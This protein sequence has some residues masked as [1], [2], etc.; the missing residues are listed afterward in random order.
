MND[1][2]PLVASGAHAQERAQGLNRRLSIIIRIIITIRGLF[3]F[4]REIRTYKYSARLSWE[5]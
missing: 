5:N 2:G 4:F 1:A 3:L